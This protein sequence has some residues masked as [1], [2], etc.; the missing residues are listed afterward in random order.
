[1]KDIDVYIDFNL[2]TCLYEKYL[3]FSDI[4][5]NSALVKTRLCVCSIFITYLPLFQWVRLKGREVACSHMTL[6]I[7]DCGL[8]QPL[9][10]FMD[11]Y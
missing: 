1:M 6:P 3:G 7:T 8:H 4:H 2:E 11:S 9:L 10:G 5:R